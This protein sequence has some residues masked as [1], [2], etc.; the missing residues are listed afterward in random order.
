MHDL[1]LHEL[2]RS[3]SRDRSRPA[4]RDAIVVEELGKRFPNGTEAV[5]GISFRVRTGEVFGILGPNGA[6]KSTT[7][8]MLATLVRPTG[9]FAEVAGFDVTDHPRGVRRRIGFAMQEVGVDELATGTELLMLHGRLHGLSRSEAARRAALLLDL[10]GMTDAAARRMGEYSGGMKRRVDLA[11][12]LI[13]LPAVLFLD[14]PTEGLDPHARSAIWETLARL[15]EALGMTVVLTTHYMEEAERLCDR[16]A[17]VDRGRI[18]AEGTPAAL[19]VA[20]DAATL[21]AAYLHTTRHAV[22]AAA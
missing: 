1:R 9:G 10:F 8:G 6:G 11:S 2:L 14:E 3:A 20:A 13:H 17:I 15:N 19:K 18:V 16:V 5:R 4:R 12:A 21:E 7:I 22:E